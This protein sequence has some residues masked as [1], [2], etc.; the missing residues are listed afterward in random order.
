MKTLIIFFISFI[1]GIAVT[2]QEVIASGGGSGII[3]GYQVDWT[4]GEPVI[5]TFTG[6]THILTQGM[7]Q[8]KLLVTGFQEIPI[9]GLDVR[10]FP[11]PAKDFLMIEIVQAGND[12]FQYGLFDMKGTKMV[13]KKM[14]SNQEE[15]DMSH[16]VSGTYLLKVLN[17]DG[18][19]LKSYK[20]FKQ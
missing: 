1:S 8:S 18:K 4:L 6:S 13:I 12:H 17:S 9:P 16:Y 20:I 15:V 7:H 10:V 3:P 2:A 11:N 14:K 19:H 5:E